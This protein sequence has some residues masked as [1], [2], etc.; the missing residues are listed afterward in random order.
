MTVVEIPGFAA[1]WCSVLAADVGQ[2]DTPLPV[3]QARFRRG[4]AWSIETCDGW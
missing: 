1:I 3:D 4:D 2:D